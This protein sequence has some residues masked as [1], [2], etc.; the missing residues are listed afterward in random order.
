MSSLHQPRGSGRLQTRSCRRSR[1][2]S[3][4]RRSGLKPFSGRIAPRECA[5]GRACGKISSDGSVCTKLWAMLTS[6]A[7]W[8]VLAT[9]HYH[10][11]AVAVAL[12]TSPTLGHHGCTLRSSSQ[13][14][15]TSTSGSGC[16]VDL[17]TQLIRY[18]WR[19]TLPLLHLHWDL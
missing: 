10:P 9:L 3:D 8:H 12:S 14:F 2:Y 18:G 13:S 11:R 6:L 16:K 4:G 15:D 7:L 19:S 17:S 1:T 5:T